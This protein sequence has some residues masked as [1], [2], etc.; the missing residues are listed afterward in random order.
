MVGCRTIKNWLEFDDD[1]D[2]DADAGI[3]NGIFTT[4]GQGQNCASV[5]R[6]AVSELL[7]SNGIK[8]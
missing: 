3:F 6:C 8:N 2:H 5:W 4:E 1:P 7:V